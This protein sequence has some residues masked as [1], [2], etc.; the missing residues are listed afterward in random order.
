MKYFPLIGACVVA[1]CST[2]CLDM[3]IPDVTVEESA[4]CRAG[5]KSIV[6][7]DGESCPADETCELLDEDL[8]LWCMK[9]KIAE[10][11]D[12]LNCPA[13]SITVSPSQQEYCVLDEN[14]EPNDDQF[15]CTEGNVSGRYCREVPA[16]SEASSVVVL[17]GQRCTA[18]QMTPPANTLR[19]HVIDVGQGDA[20]WIQ[21]PTQQNILIDGG[22]G[23]AFGKTSAGPIIADYL[24][25]HDFP[26]GSAFDAVFL[27]H[28]HSD[29]YGGLPNLF[30][31]YNL[32]NYIDPMELDTGENVSSSYKSWISMVR[33]KL[34]ESHL[35]MPAQE[36]F[37]PGEKMPADFFGP[38]VSATFLTSNKEIGKG[39]SANPNDAS[40]IFRIDY[41]GRSFL[42]TGDAT[43][44][45]EGIV[46]AQSPDLLPVNFLKV[47]HHGSTTSSSPVFLESIWPESIPRDD[48]GAFISSGRAQYSGAYLPNETIVSRLMTFINDDMLFATSAGDENKSESDAYRDDNI[49][50]VIDGAGNYYAC[51]SG[52]N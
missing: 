30:A 38:D 52:T 48:R 39:S 41:A 27:S 36:K 16:E 23:G 10:G 49:L 7:A 43:S 51:Y 47:C 15:L 25:F 32:K 22:D 14:R 24:E 40:I 35:Y 50:I 28:P 34:D 3:S 31:S 8:G 18:S 46:V 26:R 11:G 6:L 13:G 21:T 2:G 9:I 19:I 42:F 37:A 20:I 4:S 12:G 5:Y 1:L 44:E 33:G 17:E 45:Q 29:H